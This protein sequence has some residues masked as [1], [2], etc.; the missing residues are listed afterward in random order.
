MAEKLALIDKDL[1]LRLLQKTTN[2]SPPSD[3][4]LNHMADI[5]DQLQST[6]SQNLPARPK[7][8][9]L[10]DLIAEHDNFYQKYKQQTKDHPDRMGGTP[11]TTPKSPESQKGSKIW[12]NKVMQAAN[13]TGG[14]ITALLLDHIRSSKKATWND[15]GRLV[16]D[17]KPIQGSNIV[18]LISSVTKKRKIEVLPQGVEEFIN[19]LRMINT[20]DTAAPHIRR[21]QQAISSQRTTPIQSEPVRTSTPK[22][23]FGSSSDWSEYSSIRPTKKSRKRKRKSKSFDTWAS[24]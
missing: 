21:V 8:Q 20:P 13:K 15:V 7:S 3:P 11:T 19:V 10:N 2:P 6:L 12:Y 5:E 9:K 22:K 23:S 16:V 4:I 24:T 18:D 1:L 14:Q 17:G